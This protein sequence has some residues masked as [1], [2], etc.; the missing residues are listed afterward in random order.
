VKFVAQI[1]ALAFLVSPA[2]AADL[3]DEVIAEMNLARTAPRQYAQI[4]AAHTAS[5]RDGEAA[6][7]AREAIRFLQKQRPLPP[8]AVSEGIRNGALTHVLDMG[9]VG[10]RGHKGRNGSLPWDRMARFG[11]YLGGAGENINYGRHDARATVVRL[12]VDAGVRGR[13]HRKNIFNASYRVAGAAAGYHATYGSMCVIDFAG[14]FIESTGHVAS[15]T[16][17]PT[18]SL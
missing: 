18:G 4:V 14:G 9:P 3:A 12:I 1:F 10:G 6:S 8:F 15:R 17:L 16:P 7:A 11:K 5:Y 2:F 13:G